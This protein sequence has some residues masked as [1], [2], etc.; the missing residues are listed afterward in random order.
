MKWK[1][2]C[3]KVQ[4]PCLK[5]KSHILQHQII[6]LF[7]QRCKRGTL[8]LQLPKL[9]SQFL[10]TFLFFISFKNVRFTF[11]NEF[12]VFLQCSPVF[13]L[14]VWVLCFEVWQQITYVSLIQ[15]GHVICRELH[16]VKYKTFI[17]SL[18]YLLFSNR[19]C[20]KKLY[21]WKTKPLDTNHVNVGHF[22]MNVQHLWCFRLV[23]D[24]WRLSKL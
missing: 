5:T 21:R 1:G 15:V 18:L 8:N 24:F 3:V 6:L 11:L 14:Q 16:S 20:C 10:Q 22:P 2:F 7:M 17:I 23:L 4:M 13:P 12:N 9:E 19:F